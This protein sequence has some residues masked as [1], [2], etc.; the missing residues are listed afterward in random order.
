MGGYYLCKTERA[1]H[2][3]YIESIGINIYSIEELCYYF[4]ENVYL[5]DESIINQKLCDWLGEELGLRRLQKILLRALEKGEESTSFVTAIFQECGYLS[6]PEMK[7]FKEQ[8]Q[9][10]QI[11][12]Q[13][14]RRKMKADYLTGY[15]MYVSAIE[16]YNKIL[17]NRGPGRLGIHFY[18][19]VLESQ[20]GAYA[21]MFRF[22]EAAQC[23]W[24]SYLTLRSKKVYEKYLRLLPLFMSERNY[25]NRLT[26]IRADRDEARRMKD[27]TEAILLEGQQSRFADEWEGRTM[28]EQ[29]EKLKREYLKIG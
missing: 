17:D 12:P 28:A 11:E 16:E 10:I 22:E 3:Y 18:A 8:L 25:Q 7:L 27:D 6:E 21:R 15:G 13:D 29:I 1:R 26:E 5:I 24:D 20:A 14:M 19:S 23:L 4:R 2:P 9:D